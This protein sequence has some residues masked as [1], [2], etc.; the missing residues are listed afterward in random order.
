MEISTAKW[1][2]ELEMDDYNYIQQFHMNNLDDGFTTHDIATAMGEKFQQSFSS[3]SYSSYPNFTKKTITATTTT[4]LSNSS[5]ETSQTSFERPAKQP[6]TNTTWNSCITDHISPKPSSSSHILSFENSNSMLTN[7]QDFYGNHDT[8]LKLDNEMISQANIHFPPLTSKDAF[9]NQNYAP[10]AS[11]QG[12][13]RT[14]S[15]TRN[16]TNAQD[17]IIAERK[18]REKLSERFIALSAI[19]PGLKK[20]D[21][22]SVLGEAIKYVKE[23][24]ERI[25]LFEE[26]TKKR[27]VESVV[28]VKKS[29][30]SVDDDTSSSNDN[31]ESPSCE[32]LLE[33]EARISENDVLIRI[34]CEKQKGAIVK[35]LS[36][37]EKLH[38]SVVNSSVLPFGNST[39][40][41]TII[42]QKGDEF[43]MTTKDLVK[44]LRVALLK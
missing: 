23:L 17:H 16:P 32:A 9:E 35:I 33:I 43:N 26:Q 20:M 25:K 36:E 5:V 31:S 19:V 29:H 44:I 13:K 1:L 27:T 11:L 6:K 24:Q 15:M 3:E 38:L 22:A 2:S 30:L 40:D 41:V 4:T 18:R 34:H 10:K 42:A 39:L 12:I 28:F 7:P 37:V 21:K 8:S 14:Y